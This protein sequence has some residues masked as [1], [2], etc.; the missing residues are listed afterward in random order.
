MTMRAD[1]YDRLQQLEEKLLDV[2]LTEADPAEWPGHGVKIAAMDSQTRGDR[3][4]VKKNAAASGMLATRVATMIGAA[5]SFGAVTATSADTPEDG[6]K[7]LDAE[8]ASAEREASKLMQELQK[9]TK[10]R[11]F[12]RKVHGA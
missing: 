7:Q 3:Y 6:E 10:K 4:W 1:Q 12:D 2:F 11:N 5:Q 8:I 9:G